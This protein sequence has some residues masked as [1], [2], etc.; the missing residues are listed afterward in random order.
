VL[1]RGPVATPTSAGAALLPDLVRALESLAQLPDRAR[2]ARQAAL[3]IG[4]AASLTTWW[5]ASRLDRFVA[6]HPDIALDVITLASRVEPETMDVDLWLDWLPERSIR[7]STTQRPL[8]VEQVF[9]VCAPG[10]APEGIGRERLRGVPLVWKGAPETIG[11]AIEW[12]WA[13]WLPA[14]AR[15]APAAV[16]HRELGS[17]QGAAVAGAGAVLTRTL[18][19]A[20]ALAAGSLVRLLPPEDSMA[21]S[22]IHVVRWRSDLVGDSRVRRVAGWLV[23]E[24]E[25]TAAMLA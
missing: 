10:I 19:A 20:D 23:A 7:A 22:K 6:E 13:S 8:P 21:C 5:L 14:G 1:D 2:S 11:T 9:P 17:A 16:R 3:R 18:L 15:P 4:V 25:R 12:D 24:A